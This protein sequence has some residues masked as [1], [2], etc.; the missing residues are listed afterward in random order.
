MALHRA[1]APADRGGQAREGEAAWRRHFGL[2]TAARVEDAVDLMGGRDGDGRVT[3]GQFASI[4]KRPMEVKDFAH[5]PTFPIRFFWRP[6][7]LPERW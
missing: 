2:E 1:G 6:G 3:T 7:M 5:Q 4:K